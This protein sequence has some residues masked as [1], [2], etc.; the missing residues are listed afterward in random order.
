VRS[1]LSTFGALTLFIGFGISA[2]AE[3]AS[4][5]VDQYIKAAGGAKALSKI[6]TLA[7]EGTFTNGS[8]GKAGTFT[9]DTKL[10]N[11]YYSELVADSKSWIEAYNGKSAWHENGA[12]EVAT[13]LG[14]ESSQLE[15]AGQY[16]NA[17]LLNLKKTSWRSRWWG[18]RRWR[19]KTRSKLK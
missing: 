4:K 18:M 13:F 15:A 7:I 8:D 10:P 17:R 5:I 1:L 11:R 12:G 16:Y 19:A 2:R 6:Q 3:D 9:L 14:E